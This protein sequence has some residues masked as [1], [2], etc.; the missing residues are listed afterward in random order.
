MKSHIIKIENISNLHAGSGE[1]NESVIDNLIQ[2]DSITQFPVINSSSLKGALREHF[3]S[4]D[5]S[6]IEHIFGSDVK[7]KSKREAGKYR[8]FDARLLAMPLRSDKALYLMATCP[9]LLKEYFDT[10]RTFGF[11]LTPEEKQI[12][13]LT[14]NKPQVVSE[15]YNKARIEDLEIY[16]DYNKNIQNLA[17]LIGR[18][19]VLLPDDDFNTLCDNYHLPVIAR[20]H[21]DN[22]ESK[23][24]WYEQVLPRFSRMYFPV[25]ISQDTEVYKKFV[26]VITSSLVQIG[27][28]AT[29]GYGYCK[30]TVEK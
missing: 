26:S 2:R 12:C 25:L 16:A 11:T 23:N 18:N 19:C 22:G 10:I 13:S 14:A 5:S 1:A 15:K 3:K 27:A 8:F 20:N 30:L 4:E 17:S 9:A 24:L 6:L 28:N 29:V 21:L 7:D